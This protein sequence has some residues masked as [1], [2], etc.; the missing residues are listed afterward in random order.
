[1]MKKEWE[2]EI[3]KE[4]YIFKRRNVKKFLKKIRYNILK[5]LFILNYGTLF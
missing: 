2:M 3:V 5:R 4:F 1:M